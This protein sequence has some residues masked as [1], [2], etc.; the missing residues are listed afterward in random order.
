MADRATVVDNNTWNNTHIALVGKFMA[1]DEKKAHALAT[2]LG[3]DYILMICGGWLGFGGDDMNKFLWMV[4]I[5]EAQWPKDII[6]KQ[7]FGKNG[8]YEWR[9]T[10]ISETMEKSTM[11]RLSYAGFAQQMNPRSGKYGYGMVRNYAINDKKIKLKYFEEVYSTKELLVRV[12]RV[13]TKLEISRA[14]FLRKKR[15]NIK[16]SNKQK[17]IKPEILPSNMKR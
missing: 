15:K 4:R 5:A 3:A 6:Q 1:S 8:R 10:T 16:N 2:E 12:Y 17:K 7:F 14:N 9:S 11:Y 13:K